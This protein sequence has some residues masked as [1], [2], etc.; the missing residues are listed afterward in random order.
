LQN[1]F[2]QKIRRKKAFCAGKN[3]R[4]FRLSVYFT[5][6]LRIENFPPPPAEFHD[7]IRRCDLPMQTPCIFRVSHSGKKKITCRTNR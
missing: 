5:T 3:K 7:A 4:G 1:R 2:P 6:R